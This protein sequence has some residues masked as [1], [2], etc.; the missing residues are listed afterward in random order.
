MRTTAEAVQAAISSRDSK[1]S[2]NDQL[3]T[4]WAETRVADVHNE[5]D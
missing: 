3:D 5:R 4:E 2:S 1:L